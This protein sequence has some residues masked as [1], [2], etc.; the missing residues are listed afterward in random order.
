VY[1]AKYNSHDLTSPTLAAGIWVTVI[2]ATA[3]CSLLSL[4]YWWKY[5]TRRAVASPS[6]VKPGLIKL[7]CILVGTCLSLAALVAFA[8]TNRIYRVTLARQA[9]DKYTVT[10]DVALGKIDVSGLIGPGISRKISEMLNTHS[11]IHWVSVSSPG[12]LVDEALEAASVIG[13]RKDLAVVAR[14]ECN[15]ACIIVLMSG[16]Q[17]FAEWD[18]NLGFHAISP[19]TFLES[20]EEANLTALSDA[21]NQYLLGRGVPRGI[22]DQTNSIGPKKLNFVSAT[23]LVEAGALTAVLENDKIIST[24]LAKWLEI[25]RAVGQ[26]SGGDGLAAVLLSIR[27][28]SPDVVSQEASQLY[29]ALDAKDAAAFRAAIFNLIG[30]ISE[31]AMDA[32]DPEV[33]FAYLDA[34]LHQLRYLSVNESWDTCARYADGRDITVLT[35]A[36]PSAVNEEFHALSALIRSAGKSGWARRPI[37]SWAER[38]GVQI[39]A[40]SLTDSP[41][42]KM[43]SPRLESNPRVKCLWMME[44]MNEVEQLGAMHGV[45]AFRWII[46]QDKKR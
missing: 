42:G 20:L 27:L 5:G 21:A 28:S 9:Y 39:L 13:Q 33:T 15:S 34:T 41:A 43:D 30:A 7:T 23:K 26:G 10:V 1:W 8:Q 16:A 24:D 37:P 6:S 40:K 3:G 44:L 45:A 35:D 4:C 31:A 11:G 14:K 46:A 19:I 12:G 22:I 2:S 38:Q 17:R 18:L 32:A 36:S 25:E 29:A